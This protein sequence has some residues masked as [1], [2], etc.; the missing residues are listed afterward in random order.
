MG[1][2][3]NHPEHDARERSLGERIGFWIFVAIFLGIFVG[4]PVI[5]SLH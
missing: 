2:Y 4:I 5:A 3:E 1:W